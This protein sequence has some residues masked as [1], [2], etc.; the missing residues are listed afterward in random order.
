[1]EKNT[2]R[3][4]IVSF[5]NSNKYILHD[6]APYKN[7]MLARVEAE[8]NR[9]L[10]NRFPDEAFAYFTSPRVDEVNPKTDD[11]ITEYPPL[12]SSAMEKIKKVL[13]VEVENM[14]ANDRLDSNAP[15]ANINPYA[16]DLPNII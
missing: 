13:E 9:F 16:A 14:E 5:G 11:T 1:M 4:Y 7:S 3:Y 12:D 8:L 2:D 6:S 15:Y 10:R